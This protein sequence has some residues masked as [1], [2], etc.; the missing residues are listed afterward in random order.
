ME[1]KKIRINELTYSENDHPAL[2]YENRPDVARYIYCTGESRMGG[3]KYFKDA[4]ETLL[5]D[6]MPKRRL[7]GW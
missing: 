1:L 5:D 6:Y 7:R 2:I 3:G 4:A